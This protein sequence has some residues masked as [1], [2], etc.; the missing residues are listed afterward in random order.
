[1]NINEELEQIKTRMKL[2]SSQLAKFDEQFKNV[3]SDIKEL[4]GQKSQA[5]LTEAEL[6]NSSFL[7]KLATAFAIYFLSLLL[8]TIFIFVILNSLGSIPGSVAGLVSGIAGL[9]ILI[10]P[11][12]SISSIASYSGTKWRH[13]G[14]KFSRTVTIFVVITDV[15]LT[16]LL[17]SYLG[18]T[19]S[20]NSSFPGC[21]PLKLPYLAPLASSQYVTPQQLYYK[22][23]CETSTDYKLVAGQ[24][25]DGWDSGKKYPN[26][27]FT[28]GGYEVTSANSKSGTFK[29]G[30]QPCFFRKTAYSDFMFQVD[31]EFINPHNLGGGGLVF[32]ASNPPNSQGQGLETMYRVVVT[33]T[34][35]YSFFLTV[36]D[37][38]NRKGA[39]VPQ[40]QTFCV[41]PMAKA[42]IMNWNTVT[43][44][45]IASKIYLYINGDYVDQSSNDISDFGYLGVFANANGGPSKVM[46]EHAK[47]W[48]IFL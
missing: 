1:M 38:C 41:A 24:N 12:L 25:N 47:I 30:I 15:L 46:F 11:S 17:W 19:S 37:A 39:D 26:C 20:T 27:V 8:T 32:R 2:I 34:R 33:P 35:N 40:V 44:I 7:K 45:N 10:T 6:R 42:D 4:R 31:I 48:N 23:T 14:K 9:V 3:Q 16:V 29:D 43:V 28:K 21:P 22:V 18:P 5:T 13:L 36:N